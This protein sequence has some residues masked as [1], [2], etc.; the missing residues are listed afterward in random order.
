MGRLGSL[1]LVAMVAASEECGPTRQQTGEAV[2]LVWPLVIVLATLPQALVVWLWRRL[3]PSVDPA[4]WRPLA[5]VALAAAIAVP[6]LLVAKHPWRWASEALWL[7]GCSYGAVTL[8][9]TRLWL[10]RWPASALGPLL[11]PQLVATAVFVPL[12]GVLRLG[13]FDSIELPTEG[14]FIYP[15]MGGWVPGGLAVGLGI[16]LALRLRRQR[17]ATSS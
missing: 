10:W 17:R 16:E 3:K 12:A 7:F 2:L 8:A 11:G 14:L 9:A 6:T 15:G 13:L 5:L 1:L 4:W